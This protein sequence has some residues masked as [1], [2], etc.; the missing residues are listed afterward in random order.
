MM[1]LP[2]STGIPASSRLPLLHEC[3]RCD[4]DVPHSPRQS[5]TPLPD[6]RFPFRNENQGVFCPM[7]LVQ[8]SDRRTSTNVWIP[9][10]SVVGS[11]NLAKAGETD[12]VLCMHSLT[13][14]FTIMSMARGTSGWCASS[15][16]LGSRRWKAPGASFRR[17][18]GTIRQAPSFV[19]SFILAIKV[20][21]REGPW[22]RRILLDPG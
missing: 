1:F 17:P 7:D 4:S 3:D 8:S 15:P 16:A 6:H 13:F 2:K 12:R 20:G 19:R 14:S 5:P 9:G 10:A 11:F 18:G 22:R 21:G